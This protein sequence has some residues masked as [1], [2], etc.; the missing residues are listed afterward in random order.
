MREWSLHPDIPGQK[1]LDGGMM[2]ENPT[3]LSGYA[4]LVALLRSLEDDI[5]LGAL[6]PLERNI[7]AALSLEEFNSGARSDDMIG[8]PLLD[9]PTASSFYRALKRLRCNNMVAVV[10]DRKTGRYRL[11]GTFGCADPL[12]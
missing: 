11:A 8:H 7:I 1:P 12:K 6:S 9:Q 3:K 5:G 10:G 4:H 2:S